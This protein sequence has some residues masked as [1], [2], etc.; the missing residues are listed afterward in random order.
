MTTVGYGDVFPVTAEGRAVAVVLMVGGVG[1][2]GVLSGL[3]ASWFVQPTTDTNNQ[4]LEALRG[5][6]AELKTL[7]ET[8]QKELARRSSP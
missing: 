7:L 2:F 1:L 4:E 6:V 3:L 8:L 5:D